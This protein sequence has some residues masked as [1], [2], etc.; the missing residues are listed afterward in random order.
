MPTTDAHPER[1]T[2]TGADEPMDVAVIGTGHVGL[3]TSVSM[4]IIGHRV[5]ATDIDHEKIERLTR[6]E[7]PFFEP[8]LEES[9]GA[10]LSA[11]RPQVHARGGR[12]G[13]RRGGRVHLRRHAS[14]PRRRGQPDRLGAFRDRDRATRDAQPDR[15]REVDCAG[16]HGRPPRLSLTLES[17]GERYDVVSNPEFLR[18]GT[19]LADALHP[20]RIVVGAESDRGRDVMRRLYAPLTARGCPLM[21]TDIPTAELAKHASNAFLAL[22]ISFAN[23]L[24]RISERAGA[25]VSSVVDVMGADPRI[26]RAFLSA[27]LGYG[28]SASRRTSPPSSGS[29]HGSATTFP[30][31]ARWPG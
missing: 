5:A 22:K 30:C 20:D 13:R 19:A 31:C 16:R 7:A 9:L 8:G 18:E 26:G 6:G 27:G 21:E 12:R 1:V 17:G 11:G 4:A 24:A 14:P 29:R 3:I 2:H 15:H 10:E 25:D 28:G 23:A